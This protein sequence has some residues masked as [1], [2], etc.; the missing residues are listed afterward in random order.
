MMIL[1][2]E[3]EIHLLMIQS[4]EIAIGINRRAKKT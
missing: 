2:K 1:Q 3:R 4:Q